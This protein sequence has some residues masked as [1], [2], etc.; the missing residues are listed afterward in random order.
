MRQRNGNRSGLHPTAQV[1]PH[2]LQLLPEGQQFEEGFRRRFAEIL[3]KCLEN[4][5][6][7]VL[8]ECLE[9]L[10]L[11]ETPGQRPCF[12]SADAVLHQ[13]ELFDGQ[14]HGADDRARRV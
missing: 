9:P 1:R 6:L 4:L 5:L 8:Q 3:S 13:T 7:V 10:Q 11:I 14:G 2:Q 12:S